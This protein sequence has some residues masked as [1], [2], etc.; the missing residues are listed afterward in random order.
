MKNTK[1]ILSFAVIFAFAGLAAFLSHNL[2]IG[3]FPLIGGFMGLKFGRRFQN[4]LG[5]LKAVEAA[6]ANRK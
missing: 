6:K 3:I 2:A 4:D 5:N 1:L